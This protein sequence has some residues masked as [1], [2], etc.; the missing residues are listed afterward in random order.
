M[1]GEIELARGMR[2]L[3]ADGIELGTVDELLHDHFK[4]TPTFIAE[5]ADRDYWLRRVFI[6]EL[7]PDRITLCILAKDLDCHHEVALA[8]TELGGGAVQETPPGVVPRFE[9]AEP[10]RLVYDLSRLQ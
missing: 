8:E 4:V 10:A 9:P 6:R 7:A 3:T 5:M 1:A 2:V